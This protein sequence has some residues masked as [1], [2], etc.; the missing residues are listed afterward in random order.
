MD[1]NEIIIT[2][3]TAVVPAIISYA[4]A[5]YQGKNDIKKLNVE[6]KAEIDR[7]MKQHEINLEALREQHKMDLERQAKEH[8]LKIQLMQAEHE[9]KMQEEK[10]QK[11]DDIVNRFAEGFVSDMMRDPSSAA[12][13]FQDLVGL[14]DQLKNMNPKG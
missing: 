14:R 12:G 6:N 11:T 9:L 7:L 3:I 4:V 13:K 2:A 10:T 8:E 5:R 1:W